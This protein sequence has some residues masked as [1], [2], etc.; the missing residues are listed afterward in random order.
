[1]MREKSMPGLLAFFLTLLLTGSAVL[2]YFIPQQ[3]IGLLLFYGLLFL[4]LFVFRKR[5]PPAMIGWC[6]T[7]LGLLFIFSGLTKGVDP[8]GTMYKVE[9]YYVAYGMDWAM[10]LAI[11]QSFLMNAFEFLLGVGLLFKIM[12][13][14]ISILTALMMGFF[15]YTTYMDAMYNLVPDCGCFG[16]ALIL[17]NWQTFY[18]NLTILGFVLVLLFSLRKSKSFFFRNVEWNILLVAGVLFFGFQLYNYRHLPV[19]DFRTWK[20]GNLMVPEQLEPITYYLT[21]E[22]VET[23]AITELK[24]DDLPWQDS[25]WMNTWQFVSQRIVDPNLGLVHDLA[26]EDSE[27]NNITSE[28]IESPDPQFILVSWTLSE[29]NRNKIDRILQFVAQ[30]YADGHGFILLT[31]SDEH[32]IEKFLLET[33]LTIEVYRADDIAL[34]TMIRANPGLLLLQNGYVL[35]KWHWRDFPTYQKAEKLFQSN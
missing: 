31:S 10:P 25:V 32:E 5:F 19:V 24:S 16:E 22:N 20:T 35:G 6:R 17:S 3:R 27:G 8:L 28:Y 23:G 12:P 29:F 14:T 2:I 9:D 1:M 11:Y 21:Y 13:K 15:T 4:L 34:K 26:F 33:G 7:L 30:C 18:K